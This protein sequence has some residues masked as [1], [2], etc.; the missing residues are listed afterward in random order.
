MAI[1]KT[2]SKKV[3][4]EVFK[5]DKFTCQYCGNKAPDYVLEL[6]HIKA[7]ANGGSNNIIN[8]ITSC[9]DCNRGKSKNALDDNSEIQKQQNQ[10][11]LIQERRN[12]LKMIQKWHE[13]LSDIKSIES[14]I[15]LESLQKINQIGIPMDKV[16]Q[17]KIRTTIDKYGIEKV[18]SAIS[19]Q[20]YKFSNVDFSDSSKSLESIVYWSIQNKENPQ[21]SRMFYIKGILKN[22]MPYYYED[23]A[24]I[25]LIEKAISNGIDLDQIEKFAKNC[26]NFRVFKMDLEPLNKQMNY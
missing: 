16:F 6:D 15:V 26:T 25:P 22:R 23:S 24:V 21:K 17:K 14:N 1:R 3:R 4:F 2:I 19:N 8:L 12:Q 7:V 13:S 18:L 5:R 10:L 20:P 9:F 11:E